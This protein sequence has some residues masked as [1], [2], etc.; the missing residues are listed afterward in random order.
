MRIRRTRHIVNL[1]PF[2]LLS[3]A[4]YL[5]QW[6]SD[7]TYEA[8]LSRFQVGPTALAAD[9]RALNQTDR[10]LV[11]G[12]IDPATNQV[13]LE[14]LFVIPNAGEVEPPIPGEYA[15]VL[16]DA[17]G[18]VLARY[19]FTPEAIEGGPA[20]VQIAPE[21]ERE[22][23]LLQISELV[24]YV[25]GTTRV[26]IEGPGGQVLTTVTAGANLPTVTVLSP[27]GGETLGGDTIPVS[28]TA[29]DLDG[30]PLT[31][32]M[33]YSPDNGASWEMVAQNLT[34]TSI[35]LPA[36]NFV[37]GAQA[38]L[39]VWASDG[40]HTASDESDGPFTVPNH[41]PMVEI[42]QPAGDVTIAIS[43]TLGLE[44]TA[45]DVDTGTMPDEQIQWS[46]DRDGPLGNGAQLS[47]AALS[48]G[49]H[50]I[51]VRADDGQGGVATDSV[52]VTVLES[53]LPPTS[54]Y[55][56]LLMR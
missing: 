56:P 31:F 7:F 41:V 34:Q 40:I 46:S 44:A 14:P 3:V 10:L 43:Q 17:S 45:Y 39:R 2:R 23:E 6:L 25:N 33:Q 21:Q 28:W 51:T 54:V 15:I 5:P 18:G 32:N 30:D 20:P 50:T 55:L 47:V 13:T 8:L 27:N 53:P 38:R 1:S 29:S 48:V 35:E 42:T 11:M 24:S 16:R 19:P 49:T 36:I 22:V 37:A 52:R 9:L 26:D 12:T 4:L